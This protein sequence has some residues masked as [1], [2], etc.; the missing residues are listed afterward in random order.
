MTGIDSVTVTT[1]VP[2]SPGRRFRNL[3]HGDGCLVEG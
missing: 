1:I 2:V 3:H